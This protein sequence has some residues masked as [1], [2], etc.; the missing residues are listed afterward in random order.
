MSLINVYIAPDIKKNVVKSDMKRL[1]DLYYGRSFMIVGDFN[2]HSPIWGR[3][4]NLCTR[5]RLIDEM[6]I[7]EGLV[8]LG[9]E[10]HPDWIQVTRL[11]LVLGTF[12]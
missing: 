4:N 1:V 6:L 2:A 5:G 7:E 11:I 10:N 8:G 9:I 12:L 3:L